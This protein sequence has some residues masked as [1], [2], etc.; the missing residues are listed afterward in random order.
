[1]MK[2]FL[3]SLILLISSNAVLA[4]KGASIRTLKDDKVHEEKVGRRLQSRAYAANI[5]GIMQLNYFSDTGE[6]PSNADIN[7]FFDATEAFF[8]DTLVDTFGQANF[9]FNNKGNAV[10]MGF[11][12]SEF[13]PATVETDNMA[14]FLI[15]FRLQVAVR[16]LSKLYGRDDAISRALDGAIFEDY[17]VDY[18]WPING[19]NTNFYDVQEVRYQ[20]RPAR[21]H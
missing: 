13:S 7:S 5:R 12:Q 4:N 17:I 19:E 1:M 14:K 6:S 11:L 10:R 21:L 2:T 18:L 9:V 8:S 15:S 20:G 3:L 16:P